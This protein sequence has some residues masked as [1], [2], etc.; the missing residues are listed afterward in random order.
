V[1]V[2]LIRLATSLIRPVRLPVI[3]VNKQFD[4]ALNYLAFVVRECGK[5]RSNLPISLFFSLLPGSGYRRPVFKDCMH[6][7]SVPANR[8]GFP[9]EKNARNPGRL[10][11]RIQVCEPNSGRSPVFCA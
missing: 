8:R 5:W 7:Q 3:P 2:A 11:R 4:N 1:P 10:A 9:D 6:H